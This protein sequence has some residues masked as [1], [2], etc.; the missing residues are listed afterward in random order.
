ML[1]SIYNKKHKIK[2]KWQFNQFLDIVKFGFYG[3]Q[4]LESGFL[5][6]NQFETIRFLVNRII[7]RVG[8]LFI[9][10]FFIHSVTKKPLKSR[11]GK[12]VGSIQNW[13]AII[14][15][16]IILFEITNISKQLA[17]ILYKAITNFVSFKVNF[18]IRDFIDY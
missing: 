2:K 13:V 15:K 4:T 18:I 3:I 7:K 16:G 11:M 6:K 5:L 9:R 10:I 17:L 8:G 12:G 14:K 1:I